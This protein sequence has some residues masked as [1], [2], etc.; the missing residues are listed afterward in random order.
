M[1]RM[2]I[3]GVSIAYELIGDGARAITITPGGRFSKDTP[4]VRELANALAAAGYKALIWDRPNCGESDVCFDG[5]C[6]SFQNAD[7]LAK[8]IRALG[9]GPALIFGASG[10]A[11]EAL[12]TAVRHPHAVSGLFVHWLSGGAI[13]IATLPI[14]YCADSA[15]AAATRGMSAVAALPAWKEQLTRNPGNRERLLQLDA[16][17][18]VAIMRAW[19]ES[20]FPQ[21]GVPIPCLSAQD[22]AGIRVPTMILRS[23]QSDLHHARATSEAVAAMVP[24]AR[25]EEPPWGDTEWMTQLGKAL[26]GEGTLFSRLPL[27]APQVI[28]FAK[29]YGHE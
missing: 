28:A 14:S 1:A 10:A 4:G 29:S 20:F 26:S 25:L 16:E 11:R 3:D 24:G 12:L 18:F 6:E 27:L 17:R 2:D 15:I 21:A 8:L 13:G 19:A 7:A 5:E 22:L 23:G 9:I